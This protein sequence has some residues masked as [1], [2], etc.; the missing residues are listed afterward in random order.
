MLWPASRKKRS[1][2]ALARIARSFTVAPRGEIGD[3]LAI[4]L[5]YDVAPALGRF[6][7]GCATIDIADPQLS[8]YLAGR[9][10][11]IDGLAALIDA[12]DI[13]RICLVGSSKGGF[14]ALMLSRRLAERFP[15]RALSA[16]AFSPQTRLWPADRKLTLPSYRAMIERAK[17]DAPLAES[18]R[19]DGDQ[20]VD[21]SLPNLRQLVIF[22]TGHSRDVRH[23]GALTGSSVTLRPIAVSFHA[24]LLAT[25]V[26]SAGPA[27]TRVLVAA[28]VRNGLSNADMA[29]EALT[30]EEGAM[31]AELEALP[32]QP[33]L[34][35][36]VTMMTAQP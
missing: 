14:G 8:Y 13:R 9:D 34:A 33:S 28:L 18:L 21:A 1:E 7:F 3:P 24:A 22:G 10:D 4:H 32:P 35:E 29:L 31:V 12:N 26:A 11:L 20:T 30:E 15:K 19:I 6:D 5:S 27:K 23:A 2:A 25:L 17:T 36:L 16:I